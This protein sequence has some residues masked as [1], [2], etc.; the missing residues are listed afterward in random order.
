MTQ[1]EESILHDAIWDTSSKQFT[2]I[3][4]YFMHT[5]ALKPLR[6]K[7]LRLKPL[8]S[9]SLPTTICPSPNKPPN[10]WK[11]L[12][13]PDILESAIR[14]AVL[15]FETTAWIGKGR[16]LARS[17]PSVPKVALECLFQKHSKLKN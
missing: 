14:D 11:D 17:V 13:N 5:T 6:L 3:D 9:L 12:D 1:K 10:T 2:S 16:K 4:F 15:H 8:R 7:P